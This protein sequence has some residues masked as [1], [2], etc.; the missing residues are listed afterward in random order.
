MGW[1]YDKFNLVNDDNDFNEAEYGELMRHLT[2]KNL[3]DFLRDI[4]LTAND[5]KGL[6]IKTL[7]KVEA[8]S[9]E[10]DT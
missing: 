5:A 6:L 8:D 7:A 9:D 3:C 4:G 1:F 2:P 10:F